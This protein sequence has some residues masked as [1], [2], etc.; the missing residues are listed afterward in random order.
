MPARFAAA[1]PRAMEVILADITS[2]H[3]SVSNYVRTIGVSDE[4]IASLS[5]TLLTPR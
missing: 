1:D 2:R 4:T 3:G 5:E